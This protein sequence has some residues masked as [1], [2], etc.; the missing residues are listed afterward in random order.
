[1]VRFDRLQTSAPSTGTVCAKPT[2]VASTEASVQVV[3]PTGYSVSGTLSNWAV[4]TATTT[5]WPTGGTAWPGIGTA[6]NVS[7][8]TVTFPSGDLTSS[9]TLYCFNWTN[10][11]ALS[12]TASTGSNNTG[13]VTTRTSAPATIDTASY[14]TVSIAGDQISV[15][16]TVPQSFTFA[17]TGTT[18]SLGTLS[19]SSVT[20][21]PTPATATVNTNANN[22]W[23]VWASDTNTGLKSTVANH[24]I[25]DSPSAGAGSSATLSAGTE[26][27]NLGVT[28]TQTS[29][30]G[31]L[32][33]SSGYNGASAGQ[34]GGLDTTLR[35]LASSNG[36]A[37]NA[38]LTLKNNVA[39][40][41]LTNAA[42]D[43][44][45]VETVVGAAMF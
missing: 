15:S 43:Y 34:G 38:V 14:S 33:V 7:S 32:S 17:L 45:D 22:G 31:T 21:S 5:G 18:D 35:T 3:F 20:I 40:S 13:T 36:T 1:M 29:G 24:T 26:G 42:T 41:A 23:M 19:T 10:S 6:T 37:N 12:I 9:S 28:G 2:T 16:A 44:A 4:S 25:P 30:S 8:Q 11:A 27:Y 39:I